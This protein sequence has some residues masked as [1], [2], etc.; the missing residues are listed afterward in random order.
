MIFG[1][2][3]SLCFTSIVSK[4]QP[5]LS[6]PMK[7]SW[8]FA[9]SRRGSC[10]SADAVIPSSFRVERDAPVPRGPSAGR[11]ASSEMVIIYADEVQ[12]PEGHRPGDPDQRGRGIAWGMK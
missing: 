4:A 8:V 2:K 10:G 7:N 3:H 1:I 9:N 5:S 6:M 12:Q 11:G